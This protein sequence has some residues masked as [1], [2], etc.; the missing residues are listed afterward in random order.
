MPAA[1]K[2][3][4]AALDAQKVRAAFE[5]HMRDSVAEVVCRI[6]TRGWREVHGEGGGQIWAASARGLSR[7]MCGA[8]LTGMR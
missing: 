3:E 8:S 4:E 6:M 1:L 2:A 7:S 5:A